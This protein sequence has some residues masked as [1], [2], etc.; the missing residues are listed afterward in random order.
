[1]DNLK[2]LIAWPSMLVFIEYCS[3]YLLSSGLFSQVNSQV[4]ANLL[5]VFNSDYDL[6]PKNTLDETQKDFDLSLF[7]FDFAM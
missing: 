7:I 3:V 1:M 6:R 2:I 4:L 5:V